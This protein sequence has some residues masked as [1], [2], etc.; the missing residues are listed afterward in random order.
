MNFAQQVKTI[1]EAYASIPDLQD[2]FKTV[3]R[4]LLEKNETSERQHRRMKPVSLPAPNLTIKDAAK[5]FTVSHLLQGFAEPDK[6]TVEDI[7]SIRN[8]ALYA[9]AY[10]KRFHKELEPWAAKWAEPFKQ[11]DYSELMK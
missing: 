3:S 4:Y 6:F 1:K 9:Q 10:A 8:E 7:I 5:L 11:V 2:G